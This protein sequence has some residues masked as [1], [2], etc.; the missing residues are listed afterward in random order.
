MP[1]LNSINSGTNIY[2][3]AS[4]KAREKK[5]FLPRAKKIISVIKKYK[6]KRDA[7]MDIGAGFGTFCKVMNKINFLEMFMH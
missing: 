4:E 1:I 2:F 3:P 5:I 6:V 7:I